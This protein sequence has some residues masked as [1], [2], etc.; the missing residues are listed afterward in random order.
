MA[1]PV[2]EQS[3]ITHGVIGLIRDIGVEKQRQRQQDDFISTASHEM[4]TP[5]A[6]NCNSPADRYTAGPVTFAGLAF[7]TFNVAATAVCAS[8]AMF[9]STIADVVESAAPP[10]PPAMVP[11]AQS[12]AAGA[13]AKEFV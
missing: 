2:V 9:V 1:S 10:A 13:V 6:R 5:V 4:R 12:A 11:P 3:D 7:E 8:A